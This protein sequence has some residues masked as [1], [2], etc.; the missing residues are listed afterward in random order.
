MS[1]DRGLLTAQINYEAAALF[2]DAAS[3]ISELIDDIYYDADRREG[4]LEDAAFELKQMQTFLRTIYHLDENGRVVY[5][6]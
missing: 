3:P 4:E 2:G 1:D 6:R 5:T